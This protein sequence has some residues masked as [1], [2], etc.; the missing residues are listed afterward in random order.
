MPL[1]ALPGWVDEINRRR[2]HIT[3]AGLNGLLGP[4]TPAVLSTG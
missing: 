4:K 3:V 2:E 1:E